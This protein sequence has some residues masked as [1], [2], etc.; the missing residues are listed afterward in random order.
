M[1]GPQYICH[2]CPL[3]VAELLT[4]KLALCRSMLPLYL[5]EKEAEIYCPLGAL[6]TIGGGGFGFEYNQNRNK[7][8]ALSKHLSC[9]I[10]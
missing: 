9:D 2:A 6:K 7:K 8:K 10:K 4:V 1:V 5:S 3:A